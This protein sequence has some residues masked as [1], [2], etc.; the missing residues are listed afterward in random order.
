VSAAAPMLVKGWLLAGH[1]LAP[2]L[3]DA[4]SFWLWRDAAEAQR[5]LAWRDLPFYPFVATFAERPAML[6]TISPLYLGL[7]PIWLLARRHP[8][9]RTAR[10]LLPL[11]AA[12]V[13]LWI[14]LQPLALEPRFHLPALAL[15]AVPLSAGLVAFAAEGRRA[16]EAGI[17]LGLLLA[18]WIGVSAW[19]AREGIRYA[20]GMETRAERLAGK[21]GYDVAEWLDAHVAGAERVA[22]RNMTAFR[23]FVRPDIVARS[24]TRDEL[25]RVWEAYGSLGPRPWDAREWRMALGAGYGYVVMRT[26]DAA[27]SILAAPSAAVRIAF[28]GREFTVLAVAAGPPAT[29][30][31][32]R[33]SALPYFRGGRRARTAASSRCASGSSGAM[34]RACSRWAAASSRRPASASARPRLYWASSEPA[35]SSTARR[36]GP[37]ASA[38]WPS[39]RSA[40]PRLLSATASPGESR[41]ASRRWGTA[42]AS[43]PVTASALPRLCWALA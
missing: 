20:A 27:P 14:A 15:A 25:Q 9:A 11:A 1:P 2:L 28:V 13:G 43:A 23:S 35:S 24:E 6:G 26:Q 30:R 38:V 42:S 22:L 7:F 34:R 29:R 41:T 4:R 32:A 40:P 31:S 8:L 12:A 37:M 17:A 19:S 21:S 10:T 16:R 33:P 3:G 36:K 39:S 18:F 5:N